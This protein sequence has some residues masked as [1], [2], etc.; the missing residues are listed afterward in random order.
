M[1]GDFAGLPAQ[2]YLGYRP[3]RAALHLRGSALFP[4]NRGP[5]GRSLSAFSPRMCSIPPIPKGHFL[6]GQLDR[7][8]K[9]LILRSGLGATGV[10]GACPEG[11]ARGQTC[12]RTSGE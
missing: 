6:T 11:H 4:Q 2:I 7:T 3:G 1:P 10:A 8:G 9:L 12:D 5:A